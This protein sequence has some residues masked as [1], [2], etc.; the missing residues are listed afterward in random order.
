MKKIN[1]GL[2]VH[3][4]NPKSGV[5]ISFGKNPELTIDGDNF[6][7]NNGKGKK[8][9]GDYFKR[10]KDDKRLLNMH[11]LAT[12]SPN[13]WQLIETK[14]SFIGGLG[15]S[16]FER[17]VID[18][19]QHKRAK[20]FPVLDK[21]FE[22]WFEKM[23]LESYWQAASLQM[24][25]AKELNIKVTL[26]TKQENGKVASLEVIDNNE[27]RAVVPTGNATTIEKFWISNKFGFNKTVKK[28]DCDEFP[29]FDPATPDKYPVSIIHI[30]GK[31]PMQK[32][33]GWAGWWGTEQWTAV[34]NSVPKYY[35]ATF[36]NSFFITHHISVPDNYF[37]KEGLDEDGEKKLKEEFLSGLSDTLS[38][39]EE[40]NK[41]IITFNK[42]S[43]D[44]K[45]S[46]SEVK[47]TPLESPIK[48]EAFI[49]MFEA[50]NL[51]QASGHG[52]P[53]K[54]AGVQ[55]GN[56]M[57]S[58]GKEIAAE[59]AYLQDF[60]TP[61]DRSMVCQPLNMIKRLEG[62]WN[63]KRIGIERIDSYVPGSTSKDDVSHPKNEG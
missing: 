36:K 28:E 42:M 37:K 29:A 20:W 14:A 32:I 33:Y 8:E 45:G 3:Q 11:Q 6:T 51:V 61:F 47:I 27:I 49:K 25:F 4:Y 57:G 23:D 54:L 58:S 18:E 53:G 39:V 62:K 63:G 46:L 2:F 31:T 35:E 9:S 17:Q 21:D 55:L 12:E 15:F 7:E 26:H 59:A 16:L 50:A 24:A 38:S 19:G 60:L 13:K 34:A 44:G 48:D 10:G 22:D 5:S 1:D 43:L 40:A 30:I 52:I 56:D 41:V